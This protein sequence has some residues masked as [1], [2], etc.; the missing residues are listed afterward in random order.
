MLSNQCEGRV[1]SVL[2]TFD[3]EVLEVLKKELVS[4]K[5]VFELK[6]LD[7]DDEGK[8]GQIGGM[9]LWQ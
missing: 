3:P 8:L 5:D 6:D 2:A 7:E 4:I 9:I 1:Q